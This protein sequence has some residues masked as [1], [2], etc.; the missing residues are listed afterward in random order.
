MQLTHRFGVAA[1][2]EQ[3]FDAFSHLERIAPCFPGATVE[4]SGDDQLTGTVAVKLGSV[5]LLYR[6]TGRY[7]ERNPGRHRVVVEARGEDARGLGSAV[8]VVT[9]HLTGRGGVTDVEVGVDLELTGRPSHYGTAVVDEVVEKLFE[10][11]AGCL[12]AQLPD[13]SGSVGG[14][15]DGTSADETSGP[16]TRPAGGLGTRVDAAPSRARRPATPRR[17]AVEPAPARPAVLTAVRRYAPA[18]AGLAALTWV[19]LRLLRRR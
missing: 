14:S 11:F 16:G 4:A 6:G 7:L 8:A 15:G 10:Q 12:A 9:T 5:P 18:V 3:V 13:G 2:V 19:G 17:V 1:P